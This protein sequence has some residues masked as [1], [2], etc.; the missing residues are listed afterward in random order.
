[1]T[2]LEKIIY[3]AD[4]I[5]PNRSFPGVDEVRE[6]VKTDLNRAVFQALKNTI[7]FLVSKNASIYPDTFHT[8]NYFLLNKEVETIQ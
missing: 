1:M 4:Y 8:Y 2:L 7:V 6:I 5:E 3:I